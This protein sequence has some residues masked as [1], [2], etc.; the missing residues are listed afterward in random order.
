ML[1]RYARVLR[2]YVIASNNKYAIRRRN[3]YN[4]CAMKLLR[5]YLH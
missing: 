5:I 3:S 2:E 1:V 4:L